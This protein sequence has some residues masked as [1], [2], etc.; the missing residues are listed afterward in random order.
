[1]AAI[2]FGLIWTGLALLTAVGL[3]RGWTRFPTALPFGWFIFAGLPGGLGFVLVGAYGQW[4]VTALGWTGLALLVVA[5]L[6][7]FLT[8]RPFDSSW[9]E[10][11]RRPR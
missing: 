10:G 3:L 2:F 8:P 11:L 5:I 9:A 4:R 6:A 1:M 7:I